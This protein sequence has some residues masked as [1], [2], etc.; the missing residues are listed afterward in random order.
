M[1]VGATGSTWAIVLD[2][3]RSMLEETLERT[4]LVIPRE[5]TIL[6]ASECEQ[7]ETLAQFDRFPGVELVVQPRN[8]G[9][10]PSILL[11]LSRIQKVDPTARVLVV[12]RDHSV[13]DP[14]PYLEAV[15]QA[16]SVLRHAEELVTLLGARPT[17]PDPGNSW[18]LPGRR[19]N[20]PTD[21]LFYRVRQFVDQPDKRTAVELADTGGLWNTFVTAGRLSSLWMLATRFLPW[22]V[23]MFERY[24]RTIGRAEERDLLRTLYA[25]MSPVDFCRAVLARADRVAVVPFSDSGWTHQV[26]SQSESLRR[27]DEPVSKR[28]HRRSE[29]MLAR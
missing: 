15:C 7:Q 17:S 13:P 6:V 1:R 14:S 12:P 22:H 26:S 4:A 21:G 8:A 3:E 2:G 11:P 24:A 18:V 27:S 28:S 25:T 5:R 29:S 10:G 23:V 9:T 16:I 20:A 19:L